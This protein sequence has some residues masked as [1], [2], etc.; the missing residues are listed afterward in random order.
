MLAPKRVEEIVAARD[1][2]AYDAMLAEKETSASNAHHSEAEWPLVRV[3][4]PSYAR[5]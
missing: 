3:A 1:L 2:R 5:A 4:I